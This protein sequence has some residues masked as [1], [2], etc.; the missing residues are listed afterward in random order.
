MNYNCVW[1][2]EFFMVQLHQSQPKNSILLITNSFIII[3]FLFLFFAF[4]RCYRDRT[5]FDGFQSRLYFSFNMQLKLE[6]QQHIFYN[7]VRSV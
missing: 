2:H 4:R 5:R 1:Q 3:L 7:I 6:K